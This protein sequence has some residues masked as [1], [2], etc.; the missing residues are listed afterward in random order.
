MGKDGSSGLVVLTYGGMTIVVGQRF[1]RL[2]VS[3]L[4]MR[5]VMALYGWWLV[6]VCGAMTI[7]AGNRL[8]GSLVG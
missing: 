3:V 1:L 4:S 8:L 7:V 5:V 6:L 2:L